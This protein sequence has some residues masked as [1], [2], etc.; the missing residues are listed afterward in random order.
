MGRR[1][2]IQTQ[3]DAPLDQTITICL[4][5]F[6]S[7]HVGHIQLIHKAQLLAHKYDCKCG[8]FTF[9][10]NPF[11]IL[12][13]DNKQVLSFEERVFRLRQLDVDYVVSA[14]FDKQFASIEPLEFLEKLTKNKSI[15]AIVVGSDYTYGKM[16]SGNI[17]SLREFC[18]Q[19]DIELVVEK[20]KLLADGSKISS[21]Y[22]RKLVQ[23]G[24]LSQIASQLSTPYFVMGKVKPGRRDGSK[25]GRATANIEYDEK[26]EKL[27]SGVYN[28][29]V[30][31]D[32]VR[33]KAVTNV[34]AHPTFDDHNYN[35]EAH[36][37]GLNQ[38]LYGKTI[39]IEFLEKIRDIKK[40]GTVKELSQQIAKDVEYALSK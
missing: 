35:I 17:V 5:F 33:L 34:G 14:T 21:S 19:N 22:L 11:E 36:I 16:A 29:N 37:I 31:I 6:D 28:T 25:M 30:I 32:G 40:F 15:K 10:N 13:N 4:G 18:D 20:M 2:I 26:K 1:E 9:V 27:P 23:T 39:V 8:V 3:Y 7:L 38:E 24:N 12:G